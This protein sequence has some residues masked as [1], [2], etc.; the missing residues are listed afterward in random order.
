MQNLD[1]FVKI[2]AKFTARDWQLYSSMPEAEHIAKVLNEYLM[3]CVNNGCDRAQ[4]QQKMHEVM[5][6][7]SKCGATDSEPLYFLQCVLSKIY[8]N[9][10]I[11]E[12]D[13]K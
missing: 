3:Q 13:W 8:Q 7:Y 2:D 11:F 10:S 9:N 1:I 6:N 5:G 4:T 12:D